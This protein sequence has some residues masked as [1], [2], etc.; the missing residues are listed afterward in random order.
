MWADAKVALLAIFI[1]VQA[2]AHW[3][4]WY[5]RYQRIDMLTHFLGGLVVGAFLKDFEIA[6]ALIFAWEAVETLLVRENREAFRENPLNK[7]SDLFFGFLGF[8]FG[9]E[10]F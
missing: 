5:Y 9:F 10:F 3:R 6:I 2:M 7:I 4:R 1:I 8:Y